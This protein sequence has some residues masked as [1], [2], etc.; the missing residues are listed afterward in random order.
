MKKRLKLTWRQS[1]KDQMNKFQHAL[2]LEWYK[3]GKDRLILVKV[4]TPCPLELHKTSDGHYH[5]KP[6]KNLPQNHIWY[7]T[8]WICKHSCKFKWISGGWVQSCTRC[9]LKKSQMVK[10]FSPCN[11]LGETTPKSYMAWPYLN[12]GNLDKIQRRNSAD[13]QN[14]HAP[15]FRGAKC[16][17]EPHHAVQ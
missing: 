4:V 7:G 1:W 16:K 10:P 14:D 13:L 8:I 6:C 12:L 11:S 3:E 9:I 5:C 15:I 17:N 2:K